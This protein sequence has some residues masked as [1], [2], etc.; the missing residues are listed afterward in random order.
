MSASRGGL[1]PFGALL[2]HADQALGWWIDSVP[3]L[4]STAES[5]LREFE[6][7]NKEAWKARDE[8]SQACSKYIGCGAVKSRDIHGAEERY[9]PQVDL[10]WSAKLG[11]VRSS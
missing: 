1:R 4:A 3:G 10:S 8:A 6:A 9:L 11:R 2:N 5:S 7:C